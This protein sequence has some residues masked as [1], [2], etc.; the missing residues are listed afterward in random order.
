MY[1]ST[2]V[3]LECLYPD[4]SPGGFIVIDD[5][6]AIAQCRHA[7]TDFRAANGIDEEIHEI[8]WTGAFWRRRP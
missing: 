2:I 3:A 1:E 4:L 6:G 5:Y 7:V 8:D